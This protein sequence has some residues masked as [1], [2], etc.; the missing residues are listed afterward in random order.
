MLKFFNTLTRKLESFK[1]IKKWQVGMYTCGPTV[2]NYAHIGNFRAYIFE[3]LL[4][5][6]LKYKGFKVTQ[7]MNRT[8]VDDKTIKGS[9]EAKIPLEEFTGK[10][11]KAF[12]EDI[13]A[14]N[15]DP[16]EINP[17]ATK[18][19]KEMVWLIK[20][21]LKKGCA[22]KSEDGSVYFSIDKFK[23][24][25]KLSH[26]NIEELKS[27]ARVKQDEYEKQNVADFVLWKSWDS[28]DGDVYWQTDLGKGRP[29]WHIECSAMST[30]YLGKT[31]DIH[32]G[33]TDNI[34]PHH[35]NEIAQTEA[36]TGKKFVNY[37]MHCEHLLVDGRKMSKSLGNFY[38]LRD[39]L[40]KGYDTK[41]IRYLLLST[42]YR[43]PLN[44][45]FEDLDAAKS[46]VKRMEEFKLFLDDTKGKGDKKVGKTISK[47]AK[48]FEAAMDDDLNISA[49]LA[50]IFVMMSEARKI[51]L[52]K[53]NAEKIKAQI[54][55]FDEVLGL[56]LR[57]VK[58]LK[59]DEDIEAL[60]RKRELARKDKNWK[61][62]DKIRDD[63]KA[64]GIILEDTP[65]GIKW[66]RA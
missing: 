43:K 52:S 37:W 58:K 4:K 14:L 17:E 50:P 45:T 15:I 62:S 32:T 3:D 30:K 31:F 6:Y 13:K 47:A 9:Q 36:A 41:S 66:R 56:N 33:G 10:Y 26:L 35:E 60:V 18:H 20:T 51:D 16:A 65:E 54:F 8:D 24:Y 59:L 2:Y 23:G 34:F 42:H 48:E 55:R 44:F 7:V 25:G 28:K 64:K 61:E 49:A 1:P 63:L 29:G 46:A 38:T 27:G 19:I 11:K 12:E 22:Y 40:S 57:Q 53:E 39:L 21:L 5:R